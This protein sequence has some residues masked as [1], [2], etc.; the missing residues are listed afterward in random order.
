[1]TR[2]AH[3]RET[4]LSQA[5][6]WSIDFGSVVVNGARTEAAQMRE[7]FTDLYRRWRSGQIE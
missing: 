1:M 5:V 2:G 7:E 6:S 4:G 3:K